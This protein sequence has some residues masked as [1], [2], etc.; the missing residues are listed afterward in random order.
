M[1]KIKKNKKLI[2][3]AL[4][5]VNF[6]SKRIFLISYWFLWALITK[7]TSLNKITCLSFADLSLKI[8]WM[9]PSLINL[10][11]GSNNL[12]FFKKKIN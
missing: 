7:R 8:T 5:E 6:S 1:S 4:I 9:S 12:N 3:V 10:L 11:P 2:V